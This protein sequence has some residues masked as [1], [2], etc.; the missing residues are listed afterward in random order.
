MRLRGGLPDKIPLF[1]LPGAILLPR[2]RLPL[3]IFEPRYLAMLEDVL[4]TPHRL[5]GMI[6][7]RPGPE[8]QP[9]LARIGGAG[10]V[11]A[12]SETDDGRYMI[13]LT[14]I[15]R[16]RLMREVSGFAPYLSGEVSWDDFATDLAGAEEDPD[17]DREQFLRLLSRYFAAHDMRADWDSLREAD[18]EMLINSLAMLSPFEPEDKQALLEAATLGERRRML[19]TLMEFALRGGGE[20]IVQ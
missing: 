16:F 9:Q 6:Q 14:G 3:Q 5:I 17:F 18:D 10:R 20:E 11:T 19:E 15:S 13:T 4:K 8:G 2:M 12:F 1:P 7:P